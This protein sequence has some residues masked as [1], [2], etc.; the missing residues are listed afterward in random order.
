MQINT[1]LFGEIIVDDNKVITFT[2]GIIGFAELQKFTL[3]VDEDNTDARK[4]F[5]LQSLDDGTFAMPIVDP[6]AIF[7][8]YN[9]VVEDEWF[10]SL[11]EHAE[12]D[13]LVFLAMTVPEDIEQMT[14]NQ[15]APII[16]NTKTNQACQIIVDG[17]EYQVRCPIYDLLKAKNKEAG[18]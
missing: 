1:E 7:E 17:D 9:P 16:V 12:E 18:E 2:D 6:F 13:L 11:G 5:W 3:I 4:I 15:K 10:N 14:V 8:D